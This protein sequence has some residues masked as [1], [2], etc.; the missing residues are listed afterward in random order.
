VAHGNNHDFF[1]GKWAL[2]ELGFRPFFLLAGL[3]A[4][5]L[6]LGWVATFSGY[7]WYANYYGAFLWHGHEMVFGYAVAVIAGFLLTSVRN[8]TGMETARHGYLVFLVLLWLAGRI[9]PF[10]SEYLHGWIIA[11]V[12]LAFVPALAIAIGVPL[13]KSNNRRNLFFIPLFI[14]MAL[15]NLAMHLEALQL[16]KGLGF[17]GEKIAF[18]LVMVVI[19]VV[20]GRVIPFFSQSALLGYHSRTSAVLDRIAIISVVLFAIS[21]GV[22]A[23]QGWVVSFFALIAL[24]ANGLRMK[25]WYV[26]EIWSNPLLWILYVS[27]FWMLVGFALYVVEGFFPLLGKPALH[28]ITIGTIGGITLGMMARVSLGHTGRKLQVAGVTSIA[29]VM[30]NAATLVRVLLPLLRPEWYQFAIMLS[31]GLW[32]LAFALFMLVYTPILVFPRLDG[33]PG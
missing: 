29:F 23:Q 17:A 1:N 9:V 11:A 22:L 31:G 30:I 26:K 33:R 24:L 20:G 6:V 7:P 12:D 10:F 3:S 2:F 18:G 8:W 15:M 14:A 13:V 19:T 5:L 28:A 27:Y 4:I 16:L 25:G 32:V 21:L